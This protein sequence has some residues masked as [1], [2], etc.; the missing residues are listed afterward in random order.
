MALTYDDA[1][2]FSD[3]AGTAYAEVFTVPAQANKMV[4]TRGA[5]HVIYLQSNAYVLSWDGTNIS[6]MISGRIN[7]NET[8]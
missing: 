2:N 6:R 8:R 7:C 1:S 4:I 5:N 3:T